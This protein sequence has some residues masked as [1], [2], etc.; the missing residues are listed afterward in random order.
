MLPEQKK[1]TLNLYAEVI[2]NQELLIL[3]SNYN[4]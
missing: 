4:N 3:F 2:L 1:K